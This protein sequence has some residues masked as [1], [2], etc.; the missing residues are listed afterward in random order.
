MDGLG[1]LD[2]S[3][4]APSEPAATQPKQP[5]SRTEAVAD[6]FREE[7]VK[8]AEWHEASGRLAARLD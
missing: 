8:M 2:F 1:G 3:M 6:H 5:K 7:E 4:P